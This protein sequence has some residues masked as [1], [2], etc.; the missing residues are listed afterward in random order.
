VRAANWA[1]SAVEGHGIQKRP[2]TVNKYLVSA[3]QLM[4]APAFPAGRATRT[5]PIQENQPRA[6]MKMK[7][8]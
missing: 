2:L 3:L 5:K 7:F 4:E 1:M 6:G 8:L